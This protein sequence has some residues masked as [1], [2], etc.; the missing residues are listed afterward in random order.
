M[1]ATVRISVLSADFPKVLIMRNNLVPLKTTRI[2]WQ[3]LCILGIASTCY[4]LSKLQ[5]ARH[6]LSPNYGEEQALPVHVNNAVHLLREHHI[7]EFSASAEFSDSDYT[8]QRLV[9]GSYPS[10]VIHNA[11][12]LI[13]FGKDEPDCTVID[14]RE[15]VYLLRCRKNL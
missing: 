10:R 1:K 4:S 11:T 6:L 5:N 7:Q 14:V 15:F 8:Y 12:Y 2:V 13:S 3:V 9:E